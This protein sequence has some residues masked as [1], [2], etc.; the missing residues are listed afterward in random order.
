MRVRAVAV[1]AE[2]NAVAAREAL[3]A[4]ATTMAR[5]KSQKAR[6]DDDGS[7]SGST[8]GSPVDYHRRYS[9]SSTASTSDSD[10]DSNN[11]SIAK[12]ESEEKNAR[13]ELLQVHGEHMHQQ[14]DHDHTQLQLQ[15]AGTVECGTS[16]PGL[17]TPC[18]LDMHDDSTE[19]E[20][21]TIEAVQ[22]GLHCYLPLG[23]DFGSD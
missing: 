4:R 21:Q 6:D 18:Q 7:V 1:A 8:V 2:R 9:A 19:W 22:P 13:K 11:Q 5:A 14:E 15:A 20:L 10:A 17:F 23:E 3:A 12:D 16:E